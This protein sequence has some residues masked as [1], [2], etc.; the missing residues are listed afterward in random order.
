MQCLH[1]NKASQNVIRKCFPQSTRVLRNLTTFALL[2]IPMAVN[3]ELVPDCI[4]IQQAA[5]PHLTQSSHPA[6]PL[7]LIHTNP[8]RNGQIPLWFSA[9]PSIMAGSS[10]PWY[11][12]CTLQ[13]LPPHL[14][15]LASR[16]LLHL[17]MSPQRIPLQSHE[18]QC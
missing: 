1:C 2:M 18:P 17:Q 12:T 6:L 11:C 5:F 15:A 8:L 13:A 7:W 9:D 14:A 3:A 16:I 4:D 10:T